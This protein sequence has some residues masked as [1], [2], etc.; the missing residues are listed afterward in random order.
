ML[1]GGY[2]VLAVRFWILFMIVLPQLAMLDFSF[3]FDLPA[4]CRQGGP[5]DVYTLANYRYFCSAIPAIPTA[6]T[7]VDL[8]VF[9][10]TLVAA[11]FVTILDL[12]L[13]YP[14][15]YYLAQIAKGTADPRSRRGPDRALLGQ[16]DPARLRL[17]RHLRLQ[18][19]HQQRS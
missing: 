9:G 18:R 7:I 12:M 2:I 13:C 11:I 19:H 8:A 14:I 5:E 4:G 17:S 6:T 1:L 3:R 16:R 10:R 15:A